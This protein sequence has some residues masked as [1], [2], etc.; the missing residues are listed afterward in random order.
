MTF[1]HQNHQLG[2]AIRQQ[3]L[4][5]T[6]LPDASASLSLFHRKRKSIIDETYLEEVVVFRCVGHDGS[7]TIG[8]SILARDKRRERR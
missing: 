7:M 6:P 3:S 1:Q 4:R 5:S 2:E 8:A